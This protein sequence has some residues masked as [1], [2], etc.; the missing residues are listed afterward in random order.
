[1]ARL[2]CSMALDTARAAGVE[3]MVLHSTPMARSL[4]QGMG[5]DDVVT[6]EVW[7]APDSVHL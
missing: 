3:R 2:L 5:Y 1:M 7:A 6:F 4:Y